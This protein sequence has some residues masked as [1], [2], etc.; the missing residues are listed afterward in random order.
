MKRFLAAV[1]TSAVTAGMTACTED[2][3]LTS[4]D[5][6]I[7]LEFSIDN[8]GV[9]HYSISAYGQAVIATSALGMDAIGVDLDKGFAIKNIRRKK[10]DREWTQIWGTMKWPS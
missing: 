3:T 7:F 6:E 2:L 8:T 4:P 5:E 1:F 9:P 10:I